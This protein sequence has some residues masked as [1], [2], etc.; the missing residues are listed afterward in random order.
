MAA[1][2]FKFLLRGLEKGQAGPRGTAPDPRLWDSR[3][4]RLKTAMV[5]RIGMAMSCITLTL[6]VYVCVCDPF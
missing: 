3:P 4:V 5:V 2:S 6:S 1:L